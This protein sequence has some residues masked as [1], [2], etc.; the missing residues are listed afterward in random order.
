MDRQRNGKD[1]RRGPA[2]SRTDSRAWTFLTNHAHVLLAISRNPELRQREIGDL[3]GIT[4]GAAQRILHELEDEGYLARERV[5]RRNRYAV[6]GGGPLRHPLEAGRTIE[7]LIDALRPGV[8][9]TDRT[10][11]DSTNESEPR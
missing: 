3:V 9:R 5:G 10:S 4:E 7:E 11:P 6:I 2:A 1:R 8:G